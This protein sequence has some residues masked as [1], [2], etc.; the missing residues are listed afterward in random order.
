MPTIAIVVLVLAVLV[1]AWVLTRK[2]DVVKGGKATDLDSWQPRTIKPLTKVEL[3]AYARLKGIAPDCVVLPQ[4]SLSRFI[5]VKS[6]LPYGPWFYRVGRRCVDF[7]I[8]SDKGDVLGVVELTDAKN[9][10]KAD[11]RG[12]QS[13]ERTLTL[14]SIPVWHVDPEAQ[15][16]YDQLYSYIHAELGQYQA[17]SSQHGPEWHSTDIAPQR[18]GIEALEL[19]DDRWNQA[20]PT[21][22][23]RPTAFLDMAEAPTAEE[24]SGAFDQGR[25]PN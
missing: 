7:L 1:L 3:K 8:C 21:E 10:A 18:A 15:G 4:V 13:K 2:R 22:E 17:K 5:R 25:P 6:S 20:W 11:S 23:N 24:E 19:D 16:A 9:D 14:A 12:A